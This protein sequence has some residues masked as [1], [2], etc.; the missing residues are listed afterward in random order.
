MS[1]DV[2]VSLDASE[3]GSSV[4]VV[5]CWSDSVSVDSDGDVVSWGSVD[6]V[7]VEVSVASVGTSEGCS[8]SGVGSGSGVGVSS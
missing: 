1:C 7:S 5:V 8:D 4:G 2:S 6:E 3:E